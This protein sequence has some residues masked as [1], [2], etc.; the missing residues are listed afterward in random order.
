MTPKL[1]AEEVEV[2]EDAEAVF[3]YALERGW[4]D[5]LPIIPPTRQRVERMLAATHR[6]PQEV[7]ARLAPRQGEATVERVAINAVMAGCAPSALPIVIAA[8]DAI[9]DRAF[10]LNGIQA[11]TNPVG[12]MIIVNGPV[13]QAAGINSGRNALGP[14][15]RA[16]ATIGR[17]LRLCMLNIGG[18]IPGE[19]DKA[20]LGMP[21]KYTFC[22]GENEEESPWEPL[23]V[24]RGLTASD[25][26]ITVAAPQGTNNV[27][28][29]SGNAE[30][31]LY[32]IADAMMTIGNNNV[33]AGNGNPVLFISPGLARL[34]VEQGF[35]TRRSV[36]EYLH[37]HARI[38]VE[39]F[40]SQEIVPSKPM[41]NR[42]VID[43]KVCVVREPEDLLV[44]VTGGP[45]PYHTTYC[46]S[47]GDCK[48]VTRAVIYKA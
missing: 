27:L 4:T 34:L 9:A 32:I 5:G 16:N 8:V 47:L 19:T 38:P 6:S 18:G 37:L 3:E 22:L 28:V 20:I 7:V 12:P 25:S 1:Q 17:A 48:A 10:N 23:H 2:P 26:A 46:A 43:G 45:E 30:D 31:T 14:G 39:S 41:A 33:I 40:P 36:Q 13:R 21:G 44:V 35:P 11:T 29:L 15:C 42:T 24:T